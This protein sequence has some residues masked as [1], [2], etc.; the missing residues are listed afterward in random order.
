MV[1]LD[2][3]QLSPM[4]DY[5]LVCSGTSDVHVRAICDAVAEG[6]LARPE[7]IK[8]WHVEGYDTRRWVLLDF[9]HVVV[10]VFQGET[11]EYY[12]L[13]RLWGDAP[14]RAIDDAPAGAEGGER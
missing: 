11:R 9:V 10:H 1:L 5:F 7:R 13:E 6:L 3:R 4:A 2:L 8:P 14:R 12:S